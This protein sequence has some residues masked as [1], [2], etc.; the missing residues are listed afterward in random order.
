MQMQAREDEMLFQL[1]R[2]EPC[3]AKMRLRM[4]AHES[5]MITAGD[6]S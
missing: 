4:E 6:A 1:S 5:E 3:D 2:P